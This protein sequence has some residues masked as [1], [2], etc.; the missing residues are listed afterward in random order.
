MPNKGEKG[1]K[2]V[3]GQSKKGYRLFDGVLFLV[4]TYCARVL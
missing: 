3:C 2:E 1:G 4:Y